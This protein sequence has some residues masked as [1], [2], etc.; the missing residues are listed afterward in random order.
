M[1]DIVVVVVVVVFFLGEDTKGSV[2]VTESSATTMVA[3]NNRWDNRV[4]FPHVHKMEMVEMSIPIPELTK[5]PRP[6]L[7]LLPAEEMDLANSRIMD[8]MTVNMTWDH[9]LIQEVRESV[10]EICRIKMVNLV[11]GTTVLP[12]LLSSLLSTTA[13]DGILVARCSEW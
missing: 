4:P 8:E 11:V 1:F 3:R 12:L 10:L 2:V 13:L 5:L 9:Q 6:V 7:L